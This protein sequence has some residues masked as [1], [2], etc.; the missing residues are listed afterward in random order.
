MPKILSSIVSSLSPESELGPHVDPD[1]DQ[2]LVCNRK[3]GSDQKLRESPTPENWFGNYSEKKDFKNKHVQTEKLEWLS[4]FACNVLPNLGQMDPIGA[5]KNTIELDFQ[6]YLI[7]RCWVEISLVKFAM[8]VVHWWSVQCSNLHWS[9]VSS[10]FYS[11]P[12]SAVLILLLFLTSLKVLFLA[13]FSTSF[14][15]L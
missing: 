2:D 5:F 12:V 11:H 8:E 15:L 3:L 7:W 10:K 6:I 1:L 14:I 13:L 4:K 9:Q